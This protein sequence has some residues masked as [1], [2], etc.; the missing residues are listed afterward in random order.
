MNPEI[1]AD[2]DKL[3]TLWDQTIGAGPVASQIRDIDEL[4]TQGDFSP[5]K[6]ATCIDRVR[7]LIV[8]ILKGIAHAISRERQDGKITDAS[9]E[10][11]VFDYLR[12]CK[13]LGDDEWN[14]VRALHGIASDQGAHQMVASREYARITKNM[15]YEV[16]LLALTKFAGRR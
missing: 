15:A 9:S 16:A 5:T 8:E 11:G 3:L 13:F 14:M 6:Y 10:H 2:K 1:N 12:G 4:F 7:V